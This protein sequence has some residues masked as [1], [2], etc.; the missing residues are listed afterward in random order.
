MVNPPAGRQLSPRRRLF[1]RIAGVAGALLALASATAF[2]AAA[3]GGT[4]VGPGRPYRW[5]DGHSIFLDN[6]S[7]RQ[8][9]SCGVALGTEPSSRFVALDSA[10]SRAFGL[11]QTNG[12]TVDRDWTGPATVTCDHTVTLSRGPLLYLY[13]LAG[14]PFPF[15]A[16]LLLLAWWH[17]D[18][19]GRGGRW[20]FGPRS[21]LPFT[22]R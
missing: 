10:G 5:T 9:A 13:P 1:A 14:T 22:R 7:Q 16:G 6:I 15:L 3:V 8:A 21:R 2:I 17:V 18:T 20:L 19:G 12:T 11:L 4:Q